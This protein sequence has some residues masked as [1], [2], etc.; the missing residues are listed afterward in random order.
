MKDITPTSRLGCHP[1][2]PRM[3]RIA[4]LMAVLLPFFVCCPGRCRAQSF[5]GSTVRDSAGITIVESVDSAWTTETAW[6][7]EDTP[8]VEIGSRFGE[9][10]AVFGSI[11]DA[12]RFSDGRF[13]VADPMS[14]TVGVFNR[15]G[16]FLFAVG[17]RGEGPA[18]IHT[19]GGLSVLNGD[20]FAVQDLRTPKRIYF[21][22]SGDHLRT[23]TQPGVGWRG[24]LVPSIV[25]TIPDGSFFAT[26]RPKEAD[27]PP[28]RAITLSELYHFDEN[29]VDQ[30]LFAV[31]PAL[32]TVNE[33]PTKGV[34]VFG[35]RPSFATDQSGFW[36]GFPLTY[37]V[38]HYS[39]QGI[40]KIVRRSWTAETVPKE[41]K[42]EYRA[43]RRAAFEGSVPDFVERILRNEPFAESFPAFKQV[44]LSPDGHLWVEEYPTQGE[45]LAE[46]WERGFPLGRGKWSVFDPEGGWLG[47]VLMPEG[48]RV[49]EIGS[50]HVL[51][52]WKDELDVSFVHLHR[53]VKPEVP[54]TL[55]D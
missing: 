49:T 2:I 24:H 25:G 5:G 42:E 34:L 33:G 29:G 23:V 37:E 43:W 35:P 26:Y 3:Y 44:L 21:G 54:E 17:G 32:P 55:H 48:L 30:G 41:L 16:G 36:F 46:T 27:Y 39:P 14:K 47:T 6:I 45:Q 20:S 38:L 53:I 4:F 13:A 10:G 1:T 7:V 51:G 8:D 19:M 15:F 50:D 40:D 18:E 31:L 11:T 9:R 28:G 52:I 22:P 12:A